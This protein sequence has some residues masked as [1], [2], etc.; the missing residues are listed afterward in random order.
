MCI[1]SI[2]VYTIYIAGN[3]SGN[4]YGLIGSVRSTSQMLP[5]ETIMTVVI[6]VCI[7]LGNNTDSEGLMQSGYK[8]NNIYMSGSLHVTLM[9]GISGETNR[10]PFDLPESESELASGYTTEYAS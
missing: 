3:V 8:R 10:L 4:T 2:G 6:M 5:Y 9:I 7:P 1:S